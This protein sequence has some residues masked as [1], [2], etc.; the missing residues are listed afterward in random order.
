MT[1]GTSSPSL[2]R[3][4]SPRRQV[5]RTGSDPQR[6]GPDARDGLARLDHGLTVTPSASSDRAGLEQGLSA[7]SSAGS[8]SATIAPPTWRY[9]RPRVTTAVRITTARSQAP[10]GAEPAEGAGVGA[11][12]DRLELLDQL[13]RPHLR[14]AGHRAGGEGG[15]HE[16]ESVAARGRAGRSRSRRAGGPSGATR[17]RTATARAPCPAR[18]RAR[19]RCARG[20][21]SSRSRRGPSGASRGRRRAR[22]RR[23]GRR[24]AAA[25]P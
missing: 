23:P 2:Q 16:V 6:R 5:P 19:G 11:A 15:G 18:R 10:S 14:G 24:R 8:E 20:R 25:C 17:P 4:E 12:A 7:Y 13:H 22:R 21:R 9:A 1:N 3:D